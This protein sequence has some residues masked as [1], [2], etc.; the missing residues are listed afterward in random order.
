MQNVAGDRHLKT[1]DLFFVLA[2]RH[3][4]EQGLSRM[5]VCSVTCVYDCGLTYFGKLM[6]HTRRSVAYN[7][8]IRSHSVEIEC[9]VEQRLAL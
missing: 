5:F 2:N 7:D 4:I 8:A 3:R 6:R 1:R 9:R